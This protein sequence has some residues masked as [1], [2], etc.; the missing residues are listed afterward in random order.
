MR[1]PRE[2]YV[3]AVVTVP[4]RTG[5]VEMIA[6]VEMRDVAEFEAIKSEAQSLMLAAWI[7]IASENMTEAGLAERVESG[8]KRTWP[9]RAYFI[10]TCVGGERDGWCQ[11][12]RPWE[13]P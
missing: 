7:D 12:F 2:A 9:D 10:E 13:R 6:G 5:D 3:R 11:I 1:L 4:A 8:I